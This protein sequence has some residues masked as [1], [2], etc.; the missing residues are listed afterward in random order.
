MTPQGRG[1]GG[2][3]DA[4]SKSEESTRRGHPTTQEIKLL[5]ESNIEIQTQWLHGQELC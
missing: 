3:S 5:K 1:L 2:A 4:K